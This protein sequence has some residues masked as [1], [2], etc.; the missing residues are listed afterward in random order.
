M[1]WRDFIRSDEHISEFHRLSR[2]SDMNR[3]YKLRAVVVVRNNELLEATRFVPQIFNMVCKLTKYYHNSVKLEYQQIK[4]QQ[5]HDSTVSELCRQVSLLCD[6][7]NLHGLR[8]IVVPHYHALYVDQDPD[9]NAVVFRLTDH[10]RKRFVEKLKEFVPD[11]NDPLFLLW[12]FMWDLMCF[13]TS[14]SNLWISRAHEVMEESLNTIRENEH[15]IGNCLMLKIMSDMRANQWTLKAGVNL[16][17]HLP[18]KRRWDDVE[19][20]FRKESSQPCDFLVRDEGDDGN[21]LAFLS[22][23]VDFK[24]PTTLCRRNRKSGILR[25]LIQ[26]KLIQTECPVSST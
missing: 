1:R 12:C 22:L 26:F 25:F 13:N 11:E 24:Y 15:A 5:Q 9:N 4:S 19:V 16:P 8:S 14:V 23:A 21:D 3:Y 6:Y 18:L 20:F 10:G 17:F 7:I 2:F